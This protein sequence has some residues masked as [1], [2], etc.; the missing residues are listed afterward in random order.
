[1]KSVP[2]MLDVETFGID[3]GFAIARPAQRFGRNGRGKGLALV[4]S[5]S[6]AVRKNSDPTLG[7]EECHYLE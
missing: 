6:F 7:P 3:D 1:M 2:R 4:V 5:D